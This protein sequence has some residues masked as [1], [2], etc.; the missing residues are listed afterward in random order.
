MCSACW[1]ILSSALVWALLKKNRGGLHYGWDRSAQHCWTMKI[2]TKFCALSALAALAS[3]PSVHANTTNQPL[4][5][6]K[7]VWGGGRHTMA[8]L[9]DGS[10]WTWGSDVSGKLGDGHVSP[11]YSVT[12]SDSFFPLRVHG[13]G[14]AGYLTSVVA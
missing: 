7:Q 1:V 12:N 6:I 3:S 10:V 4:W 2:T 9:A 5:P 8:L 13:P 14:N 11:S